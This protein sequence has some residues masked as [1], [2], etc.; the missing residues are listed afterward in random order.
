[1][2]S[3]STIFVKHV[4]HNSLAGDVQKIGQLTDAL[5]IILCHK[6]EESQGKEFLG[7]KEIKRGKDQTGA[8]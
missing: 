2:A 8:R 5:G 1:M 6:S 3:G 7:L 4:R